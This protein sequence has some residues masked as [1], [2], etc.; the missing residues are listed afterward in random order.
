MENNI[1]G[2]IKVLNYNGKDVVILKSDEEYDFIIFHT[3]DVQEKYRKKPKDMTMHEL[4]VLY[5]EI[6]KQNKW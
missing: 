2:I 5:N 4:E 3:D 1:D 6:L